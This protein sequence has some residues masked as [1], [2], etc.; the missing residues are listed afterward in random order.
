MTLLTTELHRG[1]DGGFIVFAADRRITLGTKPSSV[2]QV[3]I[4]PVR[5]LAAGIGFFGLAELRTP[6][7]Y[8]PMSEWIQDF[9]YT[10][11]PSESLGAL[12]HRL[13]SE[14]NCVVPAKLRGQEGSGFHLAGFDTSASAEFWFV[15]NVDDHGAPT[16]GAYEAREDFQS[17]HRPKLRSGEI[18][19]YRNGDI[20]AHV[21]A[22]EKIDQA[23]RGL[24]GTPDFRSIH[25][26]RA[27]LGG[28]SSRCSPSRGFTSDT[29]RVRLL[30]NR[31]M[32]LRSQRRG[33]STCDTAYLK[34]ASGA[35][36]AS[37]L[38]S[39]S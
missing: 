30:A 22:W 26:T 37:W 8:Q 19:I 3:K 2:D 28:C 9:L 18:Q 35:S 11:Q 4:F 10:V 27:Y 25:T 36:S 38:E 31:S 12:A 23:F 5:P 7:G 20:R 14:L 1:A 24:L 15:R 34:L 33:L 13:A 39:R 6:S 17:Q 21:A 16:L 29:A 32:R